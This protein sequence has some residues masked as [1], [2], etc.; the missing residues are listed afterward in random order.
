MTLEQYAYLAEIVGVIAIVLS[1]IYLAVQ[2]KQNTDAVQ[3]T[4]R[5]TVIASDLVC[6]QT[7]IDHPDILNS[8]YTSE[9][10]SEEGKIALEGFLLTLARTREHQWLQHRSGLLDTQTME[11]FLTGLTYNMS[12]PVSRAWWDGIACRY[13]DSGFVAHVN[14]KLAEVPVHTDFIH[15]FDRGQ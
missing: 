2:T 7:M 8:M 11:S 6:I 14:E 13:F 5:H 12:F 9:T 3:A 4:S 10:L 1:L 15:P